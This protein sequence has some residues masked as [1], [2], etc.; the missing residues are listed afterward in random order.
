MP[1]RSKSRVDGVRRGLDA[2][3]DELD[4]ILH[5][6]DAVEPRA[7][8][9]E[10][11]G[12]RET[13]GSQPP[14]PNSTRSERSSSSDSGTPS[15]AGTTPGAG[16]PSGA[17]TSSSSGREGWSYLGGSVYQNGAGRKLVRPSFFI[18]PDHQR[19]L[20]ILSSVATPMGRR[21]SE[22][23]C[24]A[25]DL[26][27][28]NRTMGVFG[29]GLVPDPFPLDDIPIPGRLIDERQW[30]DL[31]R[32]AASELD[33]GA[34]P[35]AHLDRVAHLVQEALYEAGYGDRRRSASERTPPEGV[36]ER[37]SPLRP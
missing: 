18:R 20:R 8:D 4:T 11:E 12:P 36:S 28:I 21:P 23:V 25:L 16:A 17:T 19:A 30:E 37:E 22:V 5:S 2:D 6:V 31:H 26:L 14:R 1:P 27:G 34:S 3:F 35:V 29:S 32:A 33:D 13:R 10:S 24:A 7:S 9:R 15:G